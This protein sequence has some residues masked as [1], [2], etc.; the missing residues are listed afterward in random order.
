M[1]EAARTRFPIRFDAVYAALSAALL[2]PPSRSFLEV[3]PGGVR[4]QMAWAFRATFPASAVASV[5]DYDRAPLSRGVHGFAGR[6]L[7]NG[8][9][10]SIVA[11]T[12]RSPQRAYVCGFPVRLRELMVS[13]EDP[14]GVTAA[15]ARACAHGAGGSAASSV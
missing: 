14:G 9:G 2:I 6:W 13:V 3:G 11:I 12:L 10:R 7:V 15:L 8:S 1:I 4:I 5:R